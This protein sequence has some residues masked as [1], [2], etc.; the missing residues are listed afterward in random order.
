M[1]WF[2][3]GGELFETEY[4]SITE[5]EVFE[6]I[7][8][9]T[10]FYILSE[11]NFDEVR[12]HNLERIGMEAAHASAQR[13]VAAGVTA[14]LIASSLVPGPLGGTARKTVGIVTA[15]LELLVNSQTADAYMRSKIKKEIR[16]RAARA[17]E[18]QEGR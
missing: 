7:D 1:P 10:A 11:G 17:R 8:D 18:N 16:S 5:K 15:G 2:E 9:M 12:L 4:G 3:I 14:G 13:A 6:A